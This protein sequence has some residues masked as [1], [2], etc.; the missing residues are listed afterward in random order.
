VTRLRRAQATAPRPRRS[1]CSTGRAEQD[2]RVGD[3]LSADDV[4]RLVAAFGRGTPKWQLAEQHGISESSVK[5][6]LRRHR[7]VAEDP[8]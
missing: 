1:V 2:W 6:L 7:Q 8:T 3:R 4:Q 5:R